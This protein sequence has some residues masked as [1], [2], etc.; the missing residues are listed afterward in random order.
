MRSTADFSVSTLPA[1]SVERNSSSCC[2]SPVTS[3]GVE[4]GV[5]APPS[6]D[7]S[8]VLT[9][10]PAS[11]AASTTGMVPL[12]QPAS[13]AGANV[14]EVTGAVASILT[15]TVFVASTLPALSVERNRSSCSPSPLTA[16]GSGVGRPGGGPSSWYSVPASPLPPASSAPVSVIVTGPVC[17]PSVGVPET[18][19]VVTGAVSS[20]T[21]VLSR[22]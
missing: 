2:P 11:V 6:S 9:P 3:T 8:T 14:A 18:A 4:Y 1:L 5:H 22:K 17:H 12:C 21:S 7:H 16:T 20:A 10:E 13:F 15:E 19:A